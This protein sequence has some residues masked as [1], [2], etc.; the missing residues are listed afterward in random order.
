MKSNSIF[1]IALLVLGCA[2][3]SS[4][5]KDE[6]PLTTNNDNNDNDVTKKYSITANVVLANV[7]EE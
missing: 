4:C 7:W 3:F 6:I 2:V 5:K 1:G